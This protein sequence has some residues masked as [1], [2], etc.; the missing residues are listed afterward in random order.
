MMLRLLVDVGAEG[1]QIPRTVKLPVVL[2]RFEGAKMNRKSVF[3][4]FSCFA[5]GLEG[6]RRFLFA[7]WKRKLF[8]AWLLISLVLWLLAEEMETRISGIGLLFC[9]FSVFLFW[10]LKK[11]ISNKIRTWNIGPKKKFIL[12]GSLGAVWVESIFWMLETLSGVEGV[13][14]DPN[15]FLN[16]LGTMPWYILMVFFLWKVEIAHRYSYTALLMLGGIYDLF[17][18]GVLGILLARQSLAILP[19]LIIFLPNFVVSYSFMIL[20]PSFLLREETDKIRIAGKRR[21]ERYKYLYGLLPLVG[22]ILY[23][24]VIILLM[25][26]R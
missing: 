24:I 1:V 25:S 22:L 7:S 26:A 14:S 19:F 11:P 16:L 5:E 8:A 13:A 6:M 18:D 9:G 21:N 12:I 17:A 23:S 2:D 20:P 3:P 15:F 10:G 4:H